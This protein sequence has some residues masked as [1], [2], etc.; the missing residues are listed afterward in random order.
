MKSSDKNSR[1]LCYKALFYSV[2]SRN[3]FLSRWIRLMKD[4]QQVCSQLLFDEDYY[5]EHNP[6]V[7]DAGMPAIKHYIRYGRFEGRKPNN[8]NENSLY[9]AGHFYSPIVNVEEVK[10]NENKIWPLDFEIP[11]PEIDFNLAKQLDLIH[12]FAKFYKDIPFP[13]LKSSK[14]RYFYEN[15]AFSYSDGIILYSFIR[16][17]NP[18][19]IIE[20]GSGYSSALVLDTLDQLNRPNVSVT[21]IEPFDDLLLSIISYKDKRKL[22]IIKKNFQETSLS[23]FSQLIKDDILFIDSTHV[24]KT[25]SDVNYLILNVLPSL[26]NGVIIHFHDIFFPFEYP[27]N[28]VFDGRSWNEAYFLRAFLMYNNSYEILCFADMIHKYNKESFSEMPYC[29]KNHGGS[30]WIRKII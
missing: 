12:E 19:R 5:L 30:F 21:C 6:D 4:Y 16:H 3:G 29:Y 17:F 24:V 23:L 9:P 11:I 14:F 20:V 22:T 1:L 7:R 27:K 13:V 10:R 25:G 26:N 28:W 15:P 8:Y 2:F 18:K